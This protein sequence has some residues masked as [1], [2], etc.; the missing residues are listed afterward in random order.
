MN[1]FLLT[2]IAIVIFISIITPQ[3]KIDINNLMKI[4]GKMINPKTD[5]PYSGI[6][7]DYFENKVDKKLEGYY[8]N[9]LKN[10]KW[11]WW[12]VDGMI[13]STGSYRRGFMYGTWEWYYNN[14]Q[15]YSKGYYRNG[16]GTD[17][18]IEGVPSHG[19]YGKWTFWYRDGIKKS[20]QNWKNGKQNGIFI[21]W[22]ENGLKK[23][24]I[25]YKEG[26]VEG[27]K[28]YWDKQGVKINLNLESV[29]LKSDKIKTVDKLTDTD[30]AVTE[31]D[32]LKEKYVN[33]EEV[34]YTE[35]NVPFIEIITEYYSNDRIRLKGFKEEGEY[36]GDFTEWYENGKI[37]SKK[38]YVSG[39]LTGPYYI[40]Y[41]NGEL[42]EKLNYENN[43]KNGPY[44]RWYKNGNKEIEGH[45]KNRFKN[46]VWNYWDENGEKIKEIPY[47]NDKINGKYTKYLRNGTI[48]L[49]RKYVNGIPKDEWGI[50]NKL[51]SRQLE[52]IL[53]YS[54]KLVNEDDLKTALRLLN[55][56]MEKYNYNDNAIIS[57]VHLKLA[58]IYNNEMNDY[59]RAIKEY[60]KIIENYQNTKEQPFAL[61]NIIRIYKCKLS[62]GDMESIKQKEFVN[63]FPGHA[64]SNTFNSDCNDD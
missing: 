24:E 31:D 59:D 19:R 2:V 49:Y 1:R 20:I 50:S 30:I 43:Q 16:N 56:I 62:S 54:Q 52:T 18:K 13:D 27:V 17:R 60:T 15:L 34:A 41:E 61:Y 8:R 63:M 28:A 40:Y 32:L 42:K 5:K 3:S 58:D 48:E 6:V 53:D 23:S 55:S 14:G 21:I 46:N 51:N 45:Y 7:Y 9:G 39:A 37:K 22:H 4:D 38:T 26:V 64:L 11:M 25:T 29:N 33:D 12:D 44:Y 10:G 47:K 57:K 35:V 36:W